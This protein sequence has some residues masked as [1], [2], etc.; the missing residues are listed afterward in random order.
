MERCHYRLRQF[1]QWISGNW[2]AGHV[3]GCTWYKWVKINSTW[4]SSMGQPIRLAMISLPKCLFL[5]YTHVWLGLNT[6]R[7]VPQ[8][9]ILC[10]ISLR[11]HGQ[12]LFDG[13]RN[14][15]CHHTFLLHR[16]RYGISEAPQ[17]S[18]N[19]SLGHFWMLELIEGGK[20]PGLR[21]HES[22]H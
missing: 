16:R 12:S 17:I 22:F 6:C 14:I 9:L 11:K 21:Q 13:D 3:Q 18:G 1:L 4:G 10:W 15:L 19:E 7:W 20:L 8:N 5:T 2:A